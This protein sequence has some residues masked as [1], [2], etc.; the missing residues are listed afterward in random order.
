MAGTGKPELVVGLVAAGLATWVSLILLPARGGHL[1]AIPLL[2]L[3][4][5]FMRDSLV[6]GVEVAMIALRPKMRLKPGVIEFPTRLP[7]GGPRAFFNSFTSLMPGTLA[8]EPAENG[9][10]QFHCLDTD[11][12]VVGEMKVHEALVLRSLGEEGTSDG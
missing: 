4:L 11:K 8:V 9:H 7:Q 5:R 12:P 2:R 3:F 10:P 6:A 1:R